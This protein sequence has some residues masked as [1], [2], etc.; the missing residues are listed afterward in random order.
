VTKVNILRVLYGI[1]RE[2][3]GGPEDWWVFAT[4]SCSS[5]TY[6]SLFPHKLM[7]IVQRK[8]QKSQEI[9]MDIAEMYCI[10]HVPDEIQ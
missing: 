7:N 8:F 6:L 2:C 1:H 10:L 3:F 5:L 4:M 9:L